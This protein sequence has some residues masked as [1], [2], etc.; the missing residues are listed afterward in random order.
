M[1]F[2][3][4][5][6]L[7][8]LQL[9]GALAGLQPGATVRLPPGRQPAIAIKGEH[10]DPPVTI[11]ATDAVVL[12][13]EITES[14]GIIWRGGSIEAPSGRGDQDKSLAGRGTGPGYYGATVSRSTNITFDNVTFTNAKTGMVTGRNN[15]LTIRNSRFDGMRSDG[16]D[17]VG[18]SN[19]LIENNHFFGTT[20]IV[21][22]GNRR[23]SGFI[24]GDHPDVIQIW[25]PKDVPLATDITIRN[26]II[27]GATQGIN[28]FGPKGDGFQRIIVENNQLSI[29]Y[30]AAISLINCA[31]C[32]I[33][34]NTVA[35]TAD[36]LHPAN[37][38]TDN[39]TGL[40]CGNNLLA[41]PNHRVTA[42]CPKSESVPAN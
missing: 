12:G 8:G 29:R 7:A 34:F 40:F 39:S 9:G 2:L 26:N 15:G 11:D 28:T 1:L 42:P 17:S 24:D 21:A 33:R 36:A 3:I 6:V 13:L 32:R 20:P 14:S 23:D 27:E 5:A 25:A 16:I 38:R 31:D 4:T 35:S 30:P 18:N 19:V 22:T 37:V 10:F 41:L